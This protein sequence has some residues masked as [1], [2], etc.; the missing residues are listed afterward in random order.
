VR[1]E[2]LGKLKK[3]TSSGLDLPACSIVPQPTTLPRA[4]NNALTYSN[5]STKFQFYVQSTFISIKSQFNTVFNVNPGN[6]G[7]PI[8]FY[9]PRH[10]VDDLDHLY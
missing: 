8:T 7:S 9:L 6:H 1:L 3:S 10:F 4:P 2:G 5:G